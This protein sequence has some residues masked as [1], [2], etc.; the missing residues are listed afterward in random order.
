M[1]KAYEQFEYGIKDA[2]A[3]LDLV[4][5]FNA[6]PPVQNSEV[7][8]K[9]G[10]VLALTAWETYVEDRV[11]E[12]MDTKLKVV[13][14][15]YVGEF[16]KKKLHHELKNFHNPNSDRTQKLFREFLEIEIAPAWSWA[17]TDPEK[18]KESLNSWLA[19]RGDAVHRSKPV[20]N[21][22]NTPHLIKRDELEKV[23]R[24]VKELVK[25]TEVYLAKN[26]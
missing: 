14:G 16:I 19:K 4:D 13:A 18:A 6:K 5:Q 3:L 1:S 10:L 20:V 11:I 8:K 24:F 26:L 22:S 21:G 2:E 23:I 7:L 9:A 15:S 12:E 17:N 25:S